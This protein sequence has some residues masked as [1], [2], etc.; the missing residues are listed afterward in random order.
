[1]LQM[2]SQTSADLVIAML[3]SDPRAPLLLGLGS[4]EREKAL[5][6]LLDGPGGRALRERAS[7]A[8]AHALSVERLVPDVYAEWR[9]LVRDAMEYFGSHLSTARLAPKLIQQLQLPASTRP[10]KRLVQ[11]IARVPGLQKLGQ[12]IARNRHLHRAVRRELTQLENDICDVNV[13]ELRSI[14]VE[15]LGDALERYAVHLEPKIFRQASVSAVLRFTWRNPERRARERGVFKVMKP[16]I[17]DYFAEDMELLAQLARYLGSKH[18]E[19]G[20]ARHVLPETFQDV[21]RLLRHEV[22]FTRE[23]ANLRRAALMYRDVSSVRIP[24]VI[25]QLCTA[26]ITAMSEE[27]GQ[28]ITSAATRLPALRRREIAQQLLDSVIAVPLLKAGAAGMFHADPHAGNLLYNERTGQLTLLDWALTEHVSDEQRRQLAMLFAMT[29]LR[30]GPGLGRVIEAMSRRCQRRHAQQASLIRDELRSFFAAQ[31]VTRI[32]RLSDVVEILERIG[33]RG[34]RLPSQFVML[35]KVLFTLDGILHEIAGPNAS[36][37]LLMMRRLMER[38][39]A[40]P[41][42]VGWP[43]SLN[44]W[45]AVYLSATLYG[46]R[47]ALGS[48]QQLAG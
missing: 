12:V 35:R 13:E 42:Q 38:W 44:D 34:V 26:T 31:P 16:Y 28:K 41:K 5:S 15:G 21:R 3:T 23:Q 43:L 18:K 19:Y 29:L 14:I 33:W 39:I 27:R 10:E 30:D 8:I 46:S 17:P 6:A 45:I 20:F 11:L 1:M 9:P 4:A 32:P 7:C 36:I 40:H 47:V 22:N 25:P 2:N 48:L 24:E 37:E